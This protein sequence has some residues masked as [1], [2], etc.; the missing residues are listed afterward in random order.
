MRS[1]HLRGAA[2]LSQLWLGSRGCPGGASRRGRRTHST[3]S[4]LR[5]RH[6]RRKDAFSAFRQLGRR[7]G[8]LAGVSADAATHAALGIAA[9]PDSSGKTIVLLADSAERHVASGLLDAAR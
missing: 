4:F 3:A 7:E 9:H 6:R 5:V 2:Q 1:A 8:I